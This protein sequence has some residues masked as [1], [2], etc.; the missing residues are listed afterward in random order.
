MEREAARR[1]TIACRLKL[2]VV[3]H[4]QVRRAALLLAWELVVRQLA[5]R[6]EAMPMRVMPVAIAI[7]EARP[8]PATQRPG[9]AT[10]RKPA[11]AT[12]AT[13]A[14]VA[15]RAVEAML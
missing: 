15:R 9:P 3:A 10:K 6:R 8:K 5:V 14:A 7:V 12:A 11:V 13:S 1:A 2:K 4:R